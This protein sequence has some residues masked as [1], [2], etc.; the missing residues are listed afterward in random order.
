VSTARQIYFG[1]VLHNHQPVG[2]FPLV[3]EQAYQQAYLPMLKAMEK[4]PSLSFSLHY[5][6]PLTDW[7]K[8]NHPDFFQRLDDLVRKGQVEIMGGGYYEPILP[9]IPDA[10]KLGQIAKMSSFIR[11]Q[12][13]S[14]PTGLWLAERVWE[15][16]LAKILAQAGIKWTLVDDTHFRLVGLEA[17]DLF[18]YYITEEEGYFLKIFP[19]SKSLRYFIPWRPVEEVIAFLRSEASDEGIKIIVLGDDGEKFGVWPGTY[20]HCW[21]EGWIDKLFTALEDN[22][23]WLRTVKLGDYIKKFPPSGRIYLPCAAYDEMLEWALPPGKSWQYVC[24]RRQLEEEGRQDVI[25][26]MRGGFWRH[27]LVKYPEANRMHKKMLRV[28]K[29]VHKA[30]TLNEIGCGLD[31]LWR[32]QCNEPYW[33]GI[34]GGIYLADLRATTYR[35]LIQAETKADKVLR[36]NKLKVKKVPDHPLNLSWEQIDFDGDGFEEIL[37]DTDVFSLYLSPEEGG[38]IFEWDVHGKNC[39]LLAA[40]ARRPEAYHRLLT[41]TS[42]VKQ[43]S[44]EDKTVVSIHDLI[45]IKDQDLS[46][47][48]VYDRYPRSSLLDHF[49]SLNT[50]LNDFASNSYVEFGDFINKPY[51]ATLRRRDRKLQIRLKRKGI[52]KRS[53]E[54]LPVEINKEI[55]LEA[56]R[57]ELAVNYQFKNLSNSMI[58]GVFGNEW[59][60]NL[61]GGGHNELAYYQI[62]GLAMEDRLDSYGELEGVAQVILGNRGL[63]IEIEA[64]ITP[65]IKLWRFPVETISNSE[66]GIERLYQASCLVFLL[67]FS[68]APDEAISLRLDWVVK[69]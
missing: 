51:Q 63:S 38:S 54:E 9:A 6:G 36:E 1:I 25:P 30:R 56:D 5:G 55:L 50:K 18:G 64:K 65:K 52:F 53:G 67:P 35:H 10:D 69:P 57:E 66:A 20:K 24:L 11:H 29:K 46:K 43:S 42:P 23:E 12:F 41:E 19:G 62:P 45:K 59:N 32:A 34:F 68:L 8:Q 27:F 3:F 58:E 14:E 15:P 48:L 4:H 28:H 26:F 17:K 60:I 61:L 22:Q 39:N 40:L 31:E 33:H 2:N 49:F 16:Y 37:I 47:L 21:Q 44:P 13:G 7:L